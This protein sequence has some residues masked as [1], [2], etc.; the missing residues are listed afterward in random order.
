MYRKFIVT[1]LPLLVAGCA[2]LKNLL[3]QSMCRI[4]SSLLRTNR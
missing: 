2:M 1:S 3:P 4:S